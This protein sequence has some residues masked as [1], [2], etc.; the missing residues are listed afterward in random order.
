MASFGSGVSALLE[1]YT[2][3]LRLLKSLRGRHTR[4]SSV[5]LDFSEVQSL[6]DSIRSDRASVRSAYSSKLSKRGARLEK[7]DA[8]AN[9][10]LKNILKRLKSCLQNLVG[11]SGKKNQP[12]DYGSLVSLSSS[13][14]NETIRTINSL[15]RR[16]SS[17][18]LLRQDGKPR[19][20][21]FGRGS[22]HGS[23]ST[24]SGSVDQHGLKTTGSQAASASRRK[25]H[26]KPMEEGRDGNRRKADT[27]THHGRG[28]SATSIVTAGSRRTP[29]ARG[30]SR[31][32]YASGSSGSTKLG[33]IPSRRRRG[34]RASD[35]SFPHV[36]HDGP[37]Y[38]LQQYESL[39]TEKRGLLKRLFGHARS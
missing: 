10:A 9:S 16:L 35:T 33:E 1:T 25:R 13:S 2:T 14:R 22:R 32:S 7:G 24:S 8:R 31:H 29:D 26:K 30:P 6:R 23:R 20:S 17:A 34:N 5:V 37:V 19:P 12:V 36:Y 11:L 15:S 4:T 18:S 21:T 39:T 3:C 28:F 38:P 27:N